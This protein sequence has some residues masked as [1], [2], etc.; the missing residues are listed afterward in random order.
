MWGQH[1][2]IECSKR[3]KCFDSF[4][5]L[6][7]T[8]SVGLINEISMKNSNNFETLTVF[9]DLLILK[10]EMMSSGYIPT[11]SHMRQK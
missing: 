11:S 9:V 8:R 1:A 10:E 2:Q 4:E 7:I 3:L 5:R 6:C